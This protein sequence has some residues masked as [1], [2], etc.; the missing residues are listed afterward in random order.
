MKLWHCDF[1]LLASRS[2]LTP[3]K[4]N[5]KTIDVKKTFF[6]FFLFLPRFFTFF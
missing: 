6:T 3:V 5:V 2:V 4:L 1:I